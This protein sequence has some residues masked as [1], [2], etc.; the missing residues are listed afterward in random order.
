MRA[1]YVAIAAL[2]L[3]GSATYGQDK[4][5]PKAP[6]TSQPSFDCSK[7]NSA[8]ARLICADKEL[9][10]LD[11]QLAVPFRKRLS[12]LSGA[13]RDAVIADQRRWINERNVKCGLTASNKA[14]VEELVAAKPCMIDA[15]RERI[16]YLQE[17]PHGPQDSSSGAKTASE[18]PLG[19][20]CKPNEKPMDMRTQEGQHWASVCSVSETEHRFW[21]V[22]GK[23]I[24][25]Q[26]AVSNFDECVAG[27]A[28]PPPT[29]E[30]IA[31][32][33]MKQKMRQKCAVSRASIIPSVIDVN[34]FEKFGWMLLRERG[35]S[36]TRQAAF[37]VYD[38]L[39][40]AGQLREFLD[41]GGENSTFQRVFACA[42][43]QVTQDKSQDASTFFRSCAAIAGG[44]K[45][46][47]ECDNN[48]AIMR[49][50]FADGWGLPYKGTVVLIEPDDLDR[51]MF[52]D[53]NRINAMLEGFREPVRKKCGNRAIRRDSFGPS[54]DEFTVVVIST[55]D[56]RGYHVSF[57]ARTNGNNGWAYESNNIA[58]QIQVANEQRR[59]EEE[60]HRYREQ[61]QQQLRQA[62]MEQQ[63]IAQ[64]KEQ[65][66]IQAR[67][68]LRALV[69]SGA[70]PAAKTDEEKAI[71]EQVIQ[72]LRNKAVQLGPS[73][74][75]CNDTYEFFGGVVVGR[76]IDGTVGVFLVNVNA[77]FKDQGTLSPNSI[78][79]RMCGEPPSTIKSGDA[80]V[81]QWKAQFRKYDI[82]WKL[83]GM[84]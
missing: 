45:A 20:G 3:G 56:E 82:G 38:K 63:R 80:F 76:S 7:A 23:V 4:A 66:T 43:R 27:Y 42:E 33:K 35:T 57:M 5:Q 24:D 26:V 75:S 16:S 65:G 32:N 72:V 53:Q 28:L 17:Q 46:D 18:L 25:R 36:G 73:V 70:L 8:S 54:Y 83:E 74:A 77:V 21:C 37:C 15:I 14:P 81:T 60:Q 31:E 13:E 29:P 22:N 51:N 48:V 61:Q 58:N 79:S 12:K 69:E 47:I 84:L 41:E 2:L 49:D 1:L 40:D 39:A 50:G 71:I 34:R 6:A 52:L 9:A 62:Q 19:T 44:I 78:L 30:A 59:R 67:D 11:G 68:K 64:L 10:T 55:K